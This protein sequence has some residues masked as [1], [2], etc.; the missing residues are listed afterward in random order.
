MKLGGM[1]FY[2]VL[3]SKMRKPLMFTVIGYY[4]GGS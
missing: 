2:Y 4:N 1:M 3:Q